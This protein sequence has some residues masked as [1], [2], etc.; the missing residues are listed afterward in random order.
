MSESST[1]SSR[2]EHRFLFVQGDTEYRFTT[3]PYFVSDS[4]ETWTPAPISMSGVTQTNEIAKDP[5]KLSMP[6]DN[7]LAL[8]FLGTAP[9]AITTVTVYRGQVGS[10]EFNAYWKGRVAGSVIGGDTVTLDCENIFTS[11]R[12]TGLRAKYQKNCRHALYSTGCT[13]DID[14]HAYAATAV[15][16]SG[17]SVTIEPDSSFDSGFFTGGIIKTDTEMRYI[18]LHSGNTLTLL[19]PSRELIEDMNGSSGMVSVTLYPG[20]NHTMTHCKDKFNNLDNYGGYPWIPTK[21]PF[22][23]GI[24]GSIA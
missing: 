24:T 20:C 8:T 13:L 7:P 23:N 15:A 14:D 4:N 12:R 22:N 6:R 9:D 17:Y 18:S 10:T 2:I 19:Q 11:M 5:L 3:L 16:A 21:N 1:Q